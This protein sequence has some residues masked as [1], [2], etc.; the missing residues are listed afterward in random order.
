MAENNNLVIAGVVSAAAG[1][2]ISGMWDRAKN[3]DAAQTA[4]DAVGG[5]L[6]PNIGPDGKPED[7]GPVG[8]AK[9]VSQ[10]GELVVGEN[11][12]IYDDPES[13]ELNDESGDDANKTFDS[14]AEV[15][16]ASE[17]QAESYA[18]NYGPDIERFGTAPSGGA[19]SD[20]GESQKYGVAPE[21]QND[22]L[23]ERTANSNLTEEQKAG[24]DRLSNY[25]DPDN[26][27]KS[28]G[29]HVDYNEGDSGGS[30]DSSY[31]AEE[32]NYSVDV[33]D[34]GDN[35]GVGL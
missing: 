1:I 22:D 21:Q 20:P 6:G 15:V 19:L 33:I 30:D 24:F 7:M 28:W 13:G 17:E 26:L 34:S 11:N 29:G 14:L 31:S 4:K 9:E 32:D 16:G 3:S 27:S 18:R 25:D 12:V 8:D 10:S 2:A 5:D 23:N 35:P